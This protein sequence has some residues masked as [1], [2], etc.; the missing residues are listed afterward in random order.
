MTMCERK[1]F[2]LCIYNM[3]NKDLFY[4][5]FDYLISELHIS[6]TRFLSK[7][8]SAKTILFAYIIMPVFV[9][10]VLMVENKC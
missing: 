8:L 3:N 4:L 10:S 7:F 2:V 1:M 9:I 6:E 5:I